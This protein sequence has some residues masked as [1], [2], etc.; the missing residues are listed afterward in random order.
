MPATRLNSEIKEEKIADIERKKQINKE[1]K[2]KEAE[3]L[4]LQQMAARVSVTTA[5]LHAGRFADQCPL[6]IH[7]QMSA[8]KL[9]R[10]APFSIYLQGSL[11]LG[12]DCE[13]LGIP[14]DEEASRPDKEGG[15]LD[16]ASPPSSSFFRLSRLS[17][18]ALLFFLGRPY[19][20][21][22]L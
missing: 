3:K 8:K 21:G 10:Y 22:L 12:T 9:Q 6:E 18:L 7:P 11:A 4:R 15:R 16:A 2:E 20:L 19:I 1:R 5:P 13:R 17:L 14:Q